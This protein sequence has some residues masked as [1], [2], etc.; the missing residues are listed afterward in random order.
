MNDG[1]NRITV[2]GGVELDFSGLFSDTPP[3][4]PERPVEPFTGEAAPSTHEAENA[5]ET[6]RTRPDGHQSAPL[7]EAVEVYREY[8][9]NIRR[10]SELQN[11]IMKGLKAGDDLRALFLKACKAI[12]LMTSNSLFYTLAERAIAEADTRPDSGSSSSL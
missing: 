4:P 11:D 9:E 5:P 1:E 7:R 12:A 6:P 8:Q 2:A 10:S 3:E